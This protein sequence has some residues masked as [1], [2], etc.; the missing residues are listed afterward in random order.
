MKSN[1]S[2]LGTVLVITGCATP[3]VEPPQL[4]AAGLRVVAPQYNFYSTT[5]V[6]VYPSGRCESPIGFGVRGGISRSLETHELG[7]PGASEFEPD[8][9]IEHLVRAG[10]PYMLSVRYR[11][12]LVKKECVVTLKFT[13]L[14]GANYEAL[15]SSDKQ[16]CSM[17]LSEISVRADGTMFRIEV[18]KLSPDEKCERGFN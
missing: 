12:H 4:E 15:V 5:E 7:I 6:I 17:K 16:G 10:S 13:P 14:L 18:P 2:I 11:N 9:R 1:L 3:Y 8:A